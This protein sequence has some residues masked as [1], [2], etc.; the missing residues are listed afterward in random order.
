MSKHNPSVLFNS[1]TKLHA[2]RITI[3]YNVRQNFHTMISIDKHRDMS[4]YVKQRTCQR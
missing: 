1:L 3:L 2:I 4:I